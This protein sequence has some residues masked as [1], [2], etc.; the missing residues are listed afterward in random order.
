MHMIASPLHGTPYRSTDKAEFGDIAAARVFRAVSLLGSIVALIVLL[1]GCATARGYRGRAIGTVT[2]AAALSLD[3]IKELSQKG[4]SAETII[5][6]L[7][8]SGAVYNLTTDDVMELQRASVSKTVI[9]Y[10]LITPVP[11][12]DRPYRYDYYYSPWPMPYL[13]WHWDWHHDIDFG[14]HH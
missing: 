5:S 7:K 11:R 2:G 4:V 1:A 13:D 12:A 8:A 6:I 9:D 10:M 14:H 3:Q